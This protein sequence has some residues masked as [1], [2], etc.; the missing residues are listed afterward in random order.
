MSVGSTL[1]YLLDIDDLTSEMCL[2]N[3]ELVLYKILFEIDPIGHSRLLSETG[4][5]PLL[6]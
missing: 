1:T 4:M 2:S 5:N 3:V 6:R